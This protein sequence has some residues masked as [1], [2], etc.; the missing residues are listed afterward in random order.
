MQRKSQK[1]HKHFQ[2]KTFA[3]IF[4][5]CRWYNLQSAEFFLIGHWG[6][7]YVRPTLYAPLT[8]FFIKCLLKKWILKRAD[9]KFPYNLTIKNILVLLSY[10]VDFFRLKIASKK[11][12][13]FED[14]EQK[15]I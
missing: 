2:L 5:T 11:G 4:N 12:E 7:L 6:I 1:K 14:I 3:L 13:E 15:N 10:I 9:K 8:K